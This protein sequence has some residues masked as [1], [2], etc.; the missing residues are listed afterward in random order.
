MGAVCRAGHV[1]TACHWVR[2]APGPC[3]AAHRHRLPL[4][5]F[6]TGTSRAANR[7]RLP[8]GSFGTGT[9][10][11]ANRHSLPLGSFGAGDLRGRAPSQTTIG[12]VWHGDIESGQSSQTT[13]G[14]VWHGDIESG[15]SSQLTI[16]FVWRRGLAGPRA[17]TDYHW[18]RLAP[19]LARPRAV[20]AYHWVRLA[21]GTCGAAHRHSLPLGSFGAGDLRGRAPSQTTIGFVWRRGL[22]GPRS[23]HRLPLGSSENRGRHDCNYASS[24]PPRPRPFSWAGVTIP[25]VMT[26]RLARG[27]RERPIVTDYHWVR[28]APGLAEP[29]RHRLPLGSFGAG[30]IEGGQSLQLAIGFVWHGRF[31]GGALPHPTWLP[32]IQSFLRVAKEPKGTVLQGTIE[33]GKSRFLVISD[34]RRRFRRCRGLKTAL[35]RFVEY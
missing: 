24:A 31:A 2:L 23:R 16:G 26:V 3:G 12:F 11:A 1:V 25:M 27:H 15:Q 21:P 28:L 20:T 35:S 6:G 5:S 4:G 22:A 8:L 14:F 29:R 7:H 30:D 34:H 18:V 9:S 17:V 10:R 33:D 19:G 32:V 13:I